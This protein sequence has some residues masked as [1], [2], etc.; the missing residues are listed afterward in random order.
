M[1]IVLILIFTVAIAVLIAF[2]AYFSLAEISFASLNKIRLKN[3]AREGDKRAERALEMAENFDKLITTILVGNTIVNIMASSLATLLFAM[4]L[5]GIIDADVFITLVTTLVMMVMVLIFGEITPK[6]YAKANA[7]RVAMGI[8][9]SLSKVQ[10]ALTPI[11]IWFL[12]LQ[13][14]ISRRF[15]R[16]DDPIM[17]ED[18]LKVMIDEIEEEGTLQKHETEL[19]RSAIEFD[20]ITVGEIFTP[21]VDIQGV[22]VS[23][24]KYEIEYLFSSTGFSR[25]VVFDGTVDRIVG[26]INVKD[27]Y[28]QYLNSS[29]MKLNDIIRPVR[30][31]PETM[32]IST[33]L[34]DMQR[35]KTHMAAVIDPYGGT[36]GIITLEDMIEELVGEI[37]D[38]SDEVEL[39]VVKESDTVYSVLGG[40]NIHD[41]MR[42]MGLDFDPE[43]YEDHTVAGFV[44][45]KLARMPVKG[46]RIELQN[47][48]IVVKSIKDRRIREVKIIRKAAPPVSETPKE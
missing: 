47:A 29:A 24:D 16:N 31:V 27:F 36:A 37:W 35:S 28:N 12:K 41:A 48:M 11:S 43:G 38:E 25:V 19:I 46:D 1:D 17:T 8:A 23:S 2:S 7:E 32:K 13:G 9:P 42:E 15:D 40:A 30:F 34:R 44:Q 21:R 45:Y 4:V 39:P 26:V 20:D 3:M 14:R 33:L 6:C 22:D 10:V 5:A 18:E